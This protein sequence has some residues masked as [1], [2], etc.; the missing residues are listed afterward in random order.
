MRRPLK[1][2][3]LARKAASKLILPHAMLWTKSWSTV[4]MSRFQ[5]MPPFERQVCLK[6]RMTHYGRLRPVRI[7]PRC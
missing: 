3:G 6:D 5:V 2:F 1:H 4:R 7:R